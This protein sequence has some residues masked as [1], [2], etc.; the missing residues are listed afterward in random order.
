MTAPASASTTPLTWRD[1]LMALGLAGV[2]GLCSFF[3]VVPDVCGAYHDDGVYV[4]TAK[5]LAEGHGYRLLHLPGQPRQ[6]K[7]PPLFPAVL[8]LFWRLYPDYPANLRLLLTVP[9][10]C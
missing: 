10:L 7:Y 3:F 8:A 9:F 1:A 2:M 6:T 4:I 5:S